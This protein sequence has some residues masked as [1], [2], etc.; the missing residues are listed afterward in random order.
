MGAA[1]LKVFPYP[2]RDRCRHLALGDFNILPFSE[3]QDS[4]SYH[5]NPD[6]FGAWYG[7]AV[8]GPVGA[9]AA[10]AMIGRDQ[11]RGRSLVL[12]LGSQPGPEFGKKSV[13]LVRGVELKVITAAMAPF[14]GFAKSDGEHSGSAPLD[15][16][17]AA[18]TVKASKT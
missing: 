5:A 12:R 15:R 2:R 3:R 13:G 18:P 4:E 9:R 6:E 17:S 14:V 7:F 16:R 10:S 11:K 8:I 1:L